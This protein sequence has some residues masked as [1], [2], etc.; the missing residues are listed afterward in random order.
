MN[1]QKQPSGRK[2]RERRKG[3]VD[4]AKQRLITGG[5]EGLVL[6]ELADDLG[7]THGNLQYY[8][9]TKADLLRAIFDE[10][11][12]KYTTE[13][14]EA[15]QHVSTVRGR[16]SAFVD[17]SFELLESEDTRLWR[18]LIG[19]AD[20]NAELAAILQRE[21]DAYEA[22]LA[23][24]LRVL[25]PDTTEARRAHIAKIVR[26]LLDGLAIDLIYND[27]RSARM[28]GLKSEIKALLTLLFEIE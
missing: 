12:Q 27:P 21:N 8:F 6:R 26:I 7:I 2:G 17:S 4:A 20:Q 5:V 24:E 19:I 15:L 25:S 14:H 13:L 3:I 16:L 22:A 9:S 23:D 28:I 18:A 10:E 1:G 11:V